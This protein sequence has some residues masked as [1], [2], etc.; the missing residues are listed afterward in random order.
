MKNLAGSDGSTLWLNVSHQ[1]NRSTAGAEHSTVSVVTTGKCWAGPSW[2]IRNFFSSGLRVFLHAVLLNLFL[3]MCGAEYGLACARASPHSWRTCLLEEFF[4]L[5]RCPIKKNY[6]QVSKFP[7]AHI[8]FI[9]GSIFVSHV[10]CPIKK[11]N[12][13]VSKF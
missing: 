9:K 5:R 12:I 8:Q 10:W 3:Y 6:I 1:A 11:K 4:S 13:E 7:R 2:D